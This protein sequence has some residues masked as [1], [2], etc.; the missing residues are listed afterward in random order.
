LT[1]VQAKHANQQDGSSKMELMF[2]GTVLSI[3]YIGMGLAL[4]SD[5]ARMSREN[6][7]SELFIRSLS[8]FVILGWPIVLVVFGMFIIG[9]GIVDF[10]KTTLTTIY[11]G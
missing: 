7:R 5:V 2:A 8:P 10:I 4:M 6:H 11:K 1:P 9:E 3:I